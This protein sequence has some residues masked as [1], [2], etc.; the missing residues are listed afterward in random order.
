MSMDI[1]NLKPLEKEVAL[2]ALAESA[3]VMDG[4][5]PALSLVDMLLTD[6]EKVT[7]GRRILIAQMIL[8][9]ETRMAIQNKLHVSPNTIALTR[10]WLTGQLPHYDQV[11]ADTKQQI[12]L[13]EEKRRTARSK[14]KA[15]L[16]DPL[17]FARL[18]HKYPAHFLL[19]NVA[20]ELINRL[21][22]PSKS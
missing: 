4:Q 3:K 10:K 12:V 18:R 6:S 9:G 16:G 15:K 13:R 7:L 8:M 14:N 22:K 5:H 20:E 17:S 1:K 21:N 11:I 2:K 19:F